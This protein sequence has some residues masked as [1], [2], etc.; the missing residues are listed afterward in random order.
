MVLVKVYEATIRYRVYEGDD[1]DA[2][3]ALWS[4]GSSLSKALENYSGDSEAGIH[5]ESATVVA[6]GTVVEDDD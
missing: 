4:S 5:V 3:D 6:L 2:E 1:V